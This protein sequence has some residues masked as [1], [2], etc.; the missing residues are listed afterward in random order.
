M[1][2]LRVF[3]VHL[4]SATVMRSGNTHLQPASAKMDQHAGRPGDSKATN[5]TWDAQHTLYSQPADCMQR[6]ELHVR[7]S[8]HEVITPRVADRGS[9]PANTVLGGGLQGGVVAQ[10]AAGQDDI[11]LIGKDAVHRVLQLD[12]VI[13]ADGVWRRQPAQLMRC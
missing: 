5:S 3:D 12:Q 9:A 7:W 1:S 6:P 13:C 11:A 4:L 10:E 8:N 2:I